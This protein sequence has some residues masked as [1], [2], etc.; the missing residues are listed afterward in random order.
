MNLY[1]S[2]RAVNPERNINRVYEIVLSKALFNTWGVII[3]YGRYGQASK[4]RTYNFQCVEEAKSF[5][6]KVLKK[7]L[8]AP[9]RIGCAYNVV[10]HYGLKR[11][12]L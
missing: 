5:I 10:N 1:I 2:L 12:H 8:T 4:Q 3:A 11:Q 7:R 6:N 9:K